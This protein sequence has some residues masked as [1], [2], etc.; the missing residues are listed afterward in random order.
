MK[1]HYSSLKLAQ[2]ANS[3]PWS[4]HAQ[5]A[6]PVNARPA[7]PG[8]DSLIRPAS[9]TRPTPFF[10]YAATSPAH[11]TASKAW[12]GKPL[13]P[14]GPISWL[15][16]RCPS[17]LIEQD[18]RS[19]KTAE[20]APSRTLAH[21]P[22]F[23]LFSRAATSET[24]RRQPVRSA[25]M[26][27]LSGACAH[28]WE[29]A[30]PLSGFTVSL[31]SSFYPHDDSDPCQRWLLCGGHGACLFYLVTTTHGWRWCTAKAIAQARD[32]RGSTSLRPMKGRTLLLPAWWL[33][34]LPR[35]EA[36][37]TSPGPCASMIMSSLL[38]ARL[39]R[40]TPVMMTHG[41]RW[42]RWDFDPE[43]APM[44]NS[45]RSSSRAAHRAAVGGGSRGANLDEYNPT[46]SSS[47]S[48][49]ITS[50]NYS[51]PTRSTL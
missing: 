38:P 16:H 8:R 36:V 24:K 4:A 33:G 31:T 25:T 37:V 5:R 28:Q 35:P 7:W 23:A 32:D 17:V 18:S 14:L 11:Q 49:R 44:G 39:H 2:L 3:G 22:L 51:Y 50:F 21:S 26:S 20:S 34:L 10:S 19:V 27:P 30:P 9:W 42:A 45:A 29:D 40:S 1:L 13:L 41:W 43:P 48:N 46:R 47:S 15:V 12:T 6:R